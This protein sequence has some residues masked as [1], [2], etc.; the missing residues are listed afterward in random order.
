MIKHDGELKFDKSKYKKVVAVLEK[1]NYYRLNGEMML[2]VGYL[3]I[4]I[5]KN[6]L[7]MHN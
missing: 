1:F 2:H 5:R 7:H 6:M 4:C 3:I